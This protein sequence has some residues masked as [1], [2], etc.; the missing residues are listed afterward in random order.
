MGAPPTNQSRLERETGDAACACAVKRIPREDPSGI[1]GDPPRETPRPAA[2]WVPQQ[3]ARTPRG[4]P[5][6]PAGVPWE[7]R[8]A[9][10]ADPRSC[11]SPQLP[12]EQIPDPVGVP[13]CPPSRSQILWGPPSRSQILWGSPV[14]P[15]A[16]PRSLGDRQS[17]LEQIPRGPLD[18][19][20]RSRDLPG[21][22]STPEGT[23]AP[24][25]FTGRRSQQIP[26]PPGIP[27]IPPSTEPGSP[28]T[29]LRQRPPR[30][31]HGN[32]GEQHPGDTH[33]CHPAPSRRT[34]VGRVPTA[35]PVPP[36]LAASPR[37]AGEERAGR[38][39][40][41]RGRPGGARGAAGA[42]GEKRE[43]GTGLAARPAAGFG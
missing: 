8:G 39:V 9:P 26:D 32:G 5:A 33:G 38:P 35:G 36:P 2:P 27:P 1:P 42:G 17:P 34:P 18:A 20:A 10:R 7:R 11:G 16:D 14:A 21:I 19:P 31:A 3:R 40:A 6:V 24:W 12:P 4:S 28:G 23:P 30:D 13:S 22:P 25:G 37:S 41:A 29:R 15:L 43:A